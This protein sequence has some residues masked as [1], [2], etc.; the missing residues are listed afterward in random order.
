[1]KRERTFEDDIKGLAVDSYAYKQVVKHYKQLEQEQ[2]RIEAL[3]KR[4]HKYAI[5]ILKLL[6]PACGVKL[7]DISL[8]SER[9]IIELGA[10][11]RELHRV[12]T[13]C[14]MISTIMRRDRWSEE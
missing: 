10:D 6:T 13:E 5:E 8:L 7:M 3:G 4:K 12:M 9:E 2:I 1:M 11:S 14:R